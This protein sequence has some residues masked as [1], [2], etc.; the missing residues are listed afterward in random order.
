MEGFFFKSSWKNLSMAESNICMKV[1]G[2]FGQE[3][4]PLL[5]VHDSFIIQE[6][7][8]LTLE[9]KLLLAITAECDFYFKHPDLLYDR[10]EPNPTFTIEDADKAVR[11]GRLWKQKKRK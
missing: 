11:V 5:A 1:I 6:K 9:T 4:I 8:V 3:G 7:H 10:K 2:Y